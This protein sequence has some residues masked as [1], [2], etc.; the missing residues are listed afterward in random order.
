MC[1]RPE[2]DVEAAEIDVEGAGDNVSEP[3][4]DVDSVGGQCRQH[5]RWMWKAAG[6]GCRERRPMW[7]CRRPMWKGPEGDLK[8]QLLIPGSQVCTRAAWQTVSRLRLAQDFDLREEAKTGT[9]SFRIQ[10]QI[11][12]TSVLVQ[13]LGGPTQ[14]WMLLSLR[15]CARRLANRRFDRQ[16]G[17]LGTV[18]ILDS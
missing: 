8:C 11:E 4:T 12:V 14:A 2:S 18:R 10:N 5:R 9:K 7:G 13:C 17:A 3:E 15:V 16:D 6:R 1:P